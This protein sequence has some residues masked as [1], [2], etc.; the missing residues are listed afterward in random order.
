VNG[1][2]LNAAAS[3]INLVWALYLIRSGRAWKSPAIVAGGKH[4]MTDVWTSV[5][6]P[7]PWSARSYTRP[8]AY[9][10]A[11]GL[12][13][14]QASLGEVVR[15]DRDLSRAQGWED[16]RW[17]PIGPMPGI[18]MRR[19]ATGSAFARRV[20]SASSVLIC[21]SSARNVST[22]T[23]R[24]ARALS[25]TQEAGS[26]MW[27]ITASACVYTLG[28]DIAILGQ[29]PAQG[30][31]ALRALV[32]QKI[33]CAEHDPVCLLRL[34]LHRHKAHARPLGRFADRLG[35]RDVLLP[36]HDGLT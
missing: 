3:A 8:A 17:A 10:L 13:L 1:I 20:I 27:A 11:A 31:D 5:G 25:G 6:A 34:A 12:T 30:V 22:S 24:I 15:L 21:A 33:T 16:I 29:M 14:G 35:I 9:L 7:P 36:L 19:R 32:H 4:A 2:L 26:S 28:E 23:V 18:V